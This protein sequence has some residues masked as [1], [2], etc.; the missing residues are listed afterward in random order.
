ML[1]AFFYFSLCSKDFTIP[2]SLLPPACNDAITFLAGDC[3]NVIIS[4]INSS[5]DLR[6]ARVDKFSSPI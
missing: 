3:N 6:S 4:P 2:A 1:E 5:L